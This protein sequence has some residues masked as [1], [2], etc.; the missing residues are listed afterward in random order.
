MNKLYKMICAACTLVLLN[1][2]AILADSSNFAG[3]YV[4]LSMIGLG[5]EM[6][7]QSNS[8]AGESSASTTDLTVGQTAVASGLELG[9][10]L[11]LGNVMLLDV[12]ASYLHGEAKYRGKST[13]TTG[14]GPN[15]GVHA[16]DVSFSV[17]E[18]VTYYIAPTI[19]LSDT[20]SIYIKASHTSADIGVTGD[21]TTPGNLEGQGWA[22]GTRT[23]LENGIFIRTEA[24]VTEYNGISAH[25]KGAGVAGQDKIDSTTSYAAEPT[26]IQGTVSI[27]FRF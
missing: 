6:D 7:G 19:A 26:I 1:T 3:P 24:G 11:P 21:I 16:G 25:G 14:S 15:A 12:G 23:V 4:G 8:T 5:A 27:G 13:D 9:Y 20:S 17:N 10:V 2:S 22:V 18:H